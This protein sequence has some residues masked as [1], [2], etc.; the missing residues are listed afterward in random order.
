MIRAV[1]ERRRGKNGAAKRYKGPR[2][3]VGTRVHPAKKDEIDEAAVAEGASR[4]D[5]LAAA[6]ELGLQQP[7]QVAAMLRRL[8]AQQPQ[9]AFDNQ[10]V[11]GESA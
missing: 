7:A 8:R 5:W 2:E 9:L 1:T 4:N 6:I 11:F 10:E 3:L